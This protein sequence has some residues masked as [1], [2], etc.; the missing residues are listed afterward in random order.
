MSTN[1][2]TLT[3]EMAANIT[4]LQSDMQ[5]AK[6][7][8]ETA[9]KGIEGAV[10]LAKTAFIGLTG[11]ASIAAF[12]G[13]VDGVI[14][15]KV[16]L[17]RL[18]VQTGASVESLSAIG[19]V[20]KLTGTNVTDVA[21]AMNKM[22]KALATSNEDSKGASTAIKALGL[23][24]DELK[25]MRPDEQMLTVA[26]AMDKFQ[27]GGGKS[28]AAML[29]FGKSGATMLPMLQELAQKNELVGK[30]TTESALQA[31]QYEENLKKLEAAGNAWK[32]EMV[33][34]MLPA[35]DKIT[36]AMVTARKEGGALAAVWAGLST[37]LTGDDQHKNNV[38]LVEQTEKMLNLQNGLQKLRNAG[39][40][41]DTIYVRSA[42][43]EISALQEQINTTMVYRREIT[44]VA[45]A[46]SA[47]EKKRNDER[48]ANG[49]VDV[50]VPGSKKV[51]QENSGLMLLNRL[52]KQYE[53]LTASVSV[54]AQV[55]REMDAMKNGIDGTMRKEV[56][57][58]AQLIDKTET[59]KKVAESNA[60]AL[61]AQT[62]AMDQL[63][64]AQANTMAATIAE[65][66]SLREQG[67]MLGM[68]T[69]ELERY[70][71]QKKSDQNLAKL[72][73]EIDNQLEAGTLGQAEAQRR[74]ADATALANKTMAEQVQFQ[75]QRE[76]RRTDPL[77]GVDDATKD[78]A[79]KVARLG[80]SW[81]SLSTNAIGGFENAMTDMLTKGKADWKSYFQSIYAEVIR[82]QV[83]QPIMA[84]LFGVGGT[85][86]TALRGVAGGGIGG[87]F[88]GLLSGGLGGAQAAFSQT[89]LGASGFGSGLAYGNQDLAGF[90]AG[91]PGK[92]DGG[93]VSAGMPYI[94]GERQP[95][96]F[97]PHTAGTIVPSVAGKTI[98]VTNIMN[99]DSR[100]DRAA[101][102]AEVGNVLE[103]NNRQIRDAFEQR[104]L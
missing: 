16:E 61:L 73:I 74:I 87:L 1:I 29:L 52:Q 25:A 56:E 60:Q 55:E 40:T 72:Q 67:E 37:L 66:R 6:S 27:D 54:Y 102:M 18:S 59:A 34:A 92:A 43:K 28:A 8:V 9:M 65:T 11:V 71:L 57:S 20:A 98:N 68:R 36:T 89:S 33:D 50:A 91:L 58:L 104:G 30:T 80:D 75:K 53:S 81:K 86:N 76:A 17:Q 77:T 79:E 94:V 26:K 48:A 38:T 3:I 64:A 83:V 63:D 10:G 70:T 21:G 95:E 49:Q 13:I 42:K 100:T 97:I 39:Y 4:R 101:F 51:P 24:F 45:D 99:I 12:K 84:S 44:A 5:A 7:S 32:R 96:L 69:D 41:D 15:A 78:Y 35:M 46:E 14:S 90:M 85:G 93:P 88:S 103:A 82:L 62:A 23:N 19:A 47:R 31:K 22:Q 2:G